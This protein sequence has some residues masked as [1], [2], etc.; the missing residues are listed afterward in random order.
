MIKSKI[1]DSSE[2]I[3]HFDGGI[4]IANGPDILTRIG[5]DICQTEN[6]TRWNR[7]RCRGLKLLPKE[8]FYPISWPNFEM[9]FDSH[10]VNETLE[11]VEHSAAI[12]VWNDRS[13]NIWN[14][15]GT[16]NAYQVIAQSKC[17]LVYSNSVYF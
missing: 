15:I 14:K 13:K 2:L 12:H 16:N 1:A 8:V 6:R 5:E 4:L 3:E 7:E 11:L 17:P 10:G 9:Y